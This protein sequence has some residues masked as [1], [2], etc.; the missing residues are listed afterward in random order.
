[1]SP[2]SYGNSTIR[3][4]T[5]ALI[6]TFVLGSISPGALTVSTS[7]PSSAFSIRTGVGLPGPL[8]LDLTAIPPPA[9]TTSTTTTTIIITLDFF[10]LK[11][12]LKSNY[13]RYK[14]RLTAT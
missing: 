12:F 5:L 10:T 7:S 2:S 11:P 3:A 4:D 6:S 13:K 14:V 1:V 9:T 8:I